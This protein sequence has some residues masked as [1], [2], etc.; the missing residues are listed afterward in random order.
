ME[1]GEVLHGSGHALDFSTQLAGDLRLIWINNSAQID[2]G[3]G[4]GLVLML[5]SLVLPRL[6]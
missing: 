1:M 4:V 3:C 5:V 2:V 6:S